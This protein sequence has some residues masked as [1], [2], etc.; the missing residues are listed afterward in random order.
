MK[1]TGSERAKGAARPFGAKC[2]IGAV[3]VGAAFPATLAAT[4]Y[5]AGTAGG[6]VVLTG[7]NLSA[8]TVVT[9]G[10][11]AVAVL[12][13][14]PDGTGLTIRVPAYPAVT[15][16]AF[17]VANP[18]TSAATA[19]LRYVAPDAAPT[20]TRA[21]GAPNPTPPAPPAGATATPLPAP[22]RRA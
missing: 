15:T 2:D 1:R 9:V 8:S 11:A 18:G 12:A 3:A 7:T 10:G 20:P 13:A 19:T 4:F 14:S 21:A 17:T 16:L 22:A 5:N 6:P